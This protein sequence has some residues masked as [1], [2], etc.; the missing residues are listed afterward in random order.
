MGVERVT[1]KNLLIIETDKEHNLLVVRGAVPG[2]K[3]GY[4]LIKKINFQTKTTGEE[5]K[6]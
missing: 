5:K 2:A 3:G 1:V 4:L 6:E